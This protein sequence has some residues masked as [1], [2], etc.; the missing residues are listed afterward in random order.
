GHPITWHHPHHHTTN[1]NLPTYPFQHHHYWLT[2]TSAPTDATGLGLHTAT[3]P[4]LATTT[5]LP[6]G[7]WLATASLSTRH[8][9]W[10]TDHAVHHN[11]LLPGTAFLDLALHAAQA[12]GH[13][14]VEELTL[15]AP[16][17]LDRSVHLQLAVDTDHRVTVHA[18]PQTDDPDQP[19]TLHA[20]GTLTTD[21]AETTP[22][23]GITQWPPTDATAI[24]LTD[25][26]EQL[27]DHGYDYGPAFQNLTRAW[28]AD[29]TLYAEAT[30][31]P[32]TTTTGHTL[33]PALL[34]AALHPLAVQALRQNAPERMVLPYAW[35]GV[36]TYGAAPAAGATVRIRLTPTGA[37]GYAL[38]LTDE[39]GGPVAT[40][41]ALAVRPISPGDLAA[42]A[43]DRG[44]ARLHRLA[45]TTVKA[46]GEPLPA[47]PWAVLGDRTAE[48]LD[49]VRADGVEAAT[50]ADLEAAA[51]V[52]ADKPGV[53]LLSVAG[54]PVDGPEL[55]AA[56]LRTTAELLAT[57]QRWLA[58]ERFAAS[59]LVVVT[60]DATTGDLTTAPTWGLIRT[61]QT[62]HPDRITLLDLDDHPD[63]TTTLTT[64]LATALAT[65]EPQL[66]IRQ[67][68][69]HT[70]RVEP[71]TTTDEQPPTFDPEGTVLITG[72]TGGLGALIAR[73]L[74]TEHGVRHLLLTSR[75]GPTAPGAADLQAELT[76]LGATV[77]LVASDAAD[78]ESLAGL[79]AEVPAE[80][81]LTGVLHVAGVLA[82][83]LAETLTAE[84]L[85]TVF[86]PK[87]DAAWQLHELTRGC[88][89]AA[90]V[91][92]SSFAATIG[93]AGQ[94]NYAAAN[95]FLDSLAVHRRAQ[96]LPATSLAWGLWEQE[97]VGERLAG[98]DLARIART[99]VAPM[100]PDRA[101][102]LFDAA[103]RLDEPVPMP[104]ALD[105]RAMRA[106]AVAGT[107]PPVLR[108]LFPSRPAAARPAAAQAEAKRQPDSWAR[109]LAGRTAEQRFELVLGLVRENIAEVLGHAT[110]EA[111]SPR[112]GLLDLGFD[113]LMAVDL[114]NRLGGATGLRLPTTLV[115]DYPTAADLAAHL[116]DELATAAA[117][118]PADAR[119]ALA[120]LERLEAV[121]ADVP[122]GHRLRGEVALRLR[123]LLRGLDPDGATERANGAGPSIG[124]RIATASDEELFSLLD[125]E[126]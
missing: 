116:R 79:L 93:S 89:L 47:G 88:D 7:T 31:D 20:S 70:P 29:G 69:L 102:A 82:D 51:G 19:W 91:L 118:S 52:F 22:E 42:L 48:L 66:A 25:A 73:R 9:P 10:L 64:A 68:T 117:D 84:Q 49:A 87:V 115:F 34:D 85:A 121:L 62:E 13:T 38:L 111:I 108:G 124:D 65:S 101:L 53:V 94:A 83:G 37:D 59:R 105:S 122:A 41:E 24:D 126:D 107:V 39:Q 67:G 16:L 17:P 81:P 58:D 27:A 54:A 95:A 60:R 26:Y 104:V 14:T 77:R 71:A 43:G 98:A 3:H 61:T 96:G 114:R 109:Q 56:A 5:Q 11:P 45:W 92:F 12:T 57:V 80:H 78:R 123:E 33:H 30:L 63:S 97:G 18:R 112:Q 90:F 103:L 6:D 125:G 15:H 113:S 86:R 74:V 99:G 2:G 32:D 76:E 106:A 44:D 119:A 35:S 28:N 21:A 40:V 36:R 100:A 110:P 120:E 8:H 4:L 46:E 55:P 75:S 1:P 50:Y 72:A 23:P